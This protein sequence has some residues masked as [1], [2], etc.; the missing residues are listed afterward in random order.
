VSRDIKKLGKGEGGEHGGVG[1]AVTTQTG[2]E[3]SRREGCWAGKTGNKG[4]RGENWEK[5]WLMVEEENR[6]RG[7]PIATAAS[8]AGLDALGA[9]ISRPSQSPCDPRRGCLPLPYLPGAFF[10]ACGAFIFGKL[11]LATPRPLYCG[12]RRDWHP[13]DRNPIDTID[14]VL[15]DSRHG[16]KTSVL[17]VTLLSLVLLVAFATIC[18]QLNLISPYNFLPIWHLVRSAWNALLCVSVTLHSIRIRSASEILR[19]ICA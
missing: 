19:Y 4:R 9:G 10:P 11:R 5:R 17:I 18:F 3:W 12:A 7:V 13:P 6:R 2:G 8:P 14:R 16:R 1:Q 15:V